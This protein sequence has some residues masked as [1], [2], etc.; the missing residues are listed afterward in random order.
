MDLKNPSPYYSSYFSKDLIVI[1]YKL[2][3]FSRQEEKNKLLL[4][5]VNHTTRTLVNFFCIILLPV[6]VTDELFMFSKYITASRTTWGRGMHS[7]NKDLHYNLQLTLGLIT[8]VNNINKAKQ[9]G[10]K[11]W[12]Q[13]ITLLL[14]SGCNLRD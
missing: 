12:D 13:S 3:P 2:L 9:K 1:V 5:F 8:N 4:S 7:C 10:P 14:L 11:C 6:A